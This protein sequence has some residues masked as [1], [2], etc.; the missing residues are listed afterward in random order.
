MFIA[1]KG[2]FSQGKARL[3]DR[4][5]AIRQRLR[6][7][8]MATR[9]GEGDKLLTMLDGQKSFW[10][11]NNSGI[12]IAFS[13][14]IFLALC[15]CFYEP[16]SPDGIYYDQNIGGEHGCWIFKD[17]TIYITCDVHPPEKTGVY[18][19]NGNQWVSGTNPANMFIIKPSLFGVKVIC[20]QFQKGQEFW[21]R[22]SLSWVIYVVD[23]KDSI[24][25]HLSP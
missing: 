21:P 24:L 3:P 4:K 20:K 9:L 5:P 18:Y 11:R 19:K 17:G 16:A 15:V 13:V 1:A 23:L 12:W 10:R 22:N 7:K 8:I 14:I 25:S 2:Y 6:G